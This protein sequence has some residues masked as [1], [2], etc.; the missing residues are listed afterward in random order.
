M[1]ECEIQKHVFTYI[2]MSV[3]FRDIDVR[4][5]VKLFDS[6]NEKGLLFLHFL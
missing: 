5:M 6:E 1:P 3:N 4:N 2:Y